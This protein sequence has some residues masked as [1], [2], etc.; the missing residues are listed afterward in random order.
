MLPQG[1]WWQTAA[2][3]RD[4]SCVERFAE[5][6]TVHGGQPQAVKHVSMDRSRSF[7]AGAAEHFPHAKRWLSWAGRCRL[8]PFKRLARTLTTHLTGILNGF[9]AG[10]HNGRVEAMNRALQEA[11]ARARG[12]RRVE[13]FIAMAYLIAGKLTH[14]PTPPFAHVVGAALISHRT[15]SKWS[16]TTSA[17]ASVWRRRRTSSR[18]TAADPSAVRHEAPLSA[19]HRPLR[20]L[21]L[22]QGASRS[23]SQ[24]PWL[25]RR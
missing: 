16:R 21:L 20:R 18:R 8:D 11:R 22:S 25:S 12:Y 24:F 6:L 15:G 23:R 1:R 4:K 3:G 5:D 10:K 19:S 2:P 13:N 17:C 9:E 7:Q 14:L